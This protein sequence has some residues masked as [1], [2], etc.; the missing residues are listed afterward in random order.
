MPL[1]LACTVLSA[2]LPVTATAADAVISHQ[3]ATWDPI[4]FKPAIDNATNEQCLACHQEIL[5]RKV[6]KASPAGVTASEALA[7]YQTL[8]TYQGE[9]DSFHRRHLVTDYAKQVMNL[10]C[11]TCHQ[12]NDPRDE[13]ANSSA[14]GSANLTQRKMVA[15]EVCLMCHG[16]FATEAMSLPDNWPTVRDGFNNDC[17]ICHVGI[18]TE[19]HKSSFL[20]ADAIEAAGK[21]SGDA[22]YGCHGGRAWYR[23]VYPY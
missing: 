11:N 18:L 21:R 23:I 7:W 17:L 19:R 8:D 4:H 1:V 5:D 22:C 3:A 6:R 2:T 13:T 16:Q 15:A 14:T 20:N 9:Q 12:G 10:R